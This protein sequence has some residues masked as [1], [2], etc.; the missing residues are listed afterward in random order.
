[1]PGNVAVEQPGAG[2]VR[3][4]GQQQPALGRQHGHVAPDR[5]V[6]PQARQV[7]GRVEDEALLR[8]RGDVGRAAEDEEIVAL[9]EGG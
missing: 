1:V 5:V 3:L 8:A 2:V 9:G 6:A 4:E 7:D